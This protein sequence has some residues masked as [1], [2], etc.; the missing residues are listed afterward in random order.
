MADT[1]I[2][3]LTALTGAN[4]VSGDLLTIVDI[5]DTTMA[6]T[7]TNKKI[8]LTELQSA[9]VSA[10]TANGVLYLNG[11]KVATSGSA[12]VFDG[13]NLGIGTTS[14]SVKLQV[15]N[16]INGTPF[17]WGNATR[18]GYLYQDQN[19]VGITNASGTSFDEGVYLDTANSKVILYT[20]STDRVTLD[21]SGNLGLGVT[22]SAWTSYKAM[23]LSGSAYI[24]GFGNDE[25]GLGQGAYYSS[26]WK[27]AATGVPAT[28]YIAYRGSHIWQ[29]AP[30]G[31][32][33]NAITFTQA[34]T[35][36]ASG[37]LGIGTSSIFGKL[38]IADST[39]G[40]FEVTCVSA[41]VNLEVL[42][43]GR[44]NAADLNFYS[45]TVTFNTKDG[46]AYTEKARID[47]SGNLLVGATSQ[48]T[49]EKFLAD[50]TGASAKA[51]TARNNAGSGAATIFVWNS[52]TS[53]DNLFIGFGTEANGSQR[54]SI[55]YNRTGGL[56]A[57]NTTS[58][59]R[60]KD[61][62]GPVQNS[63]ALIDSV[64]VYMGKMKGATQERPMFI[65]HE[66]PA[67]AHTGEKDTVDADGNPVYQ[68]MDAS[69]LIPVMWAELQ[70]LRA[71][72]AA[73]ES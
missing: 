7:G 51:I 38:N 6:A 8:T 13:T 41:G 18:T 61:I 54:G 30:S 37:N 39:N 31:T 9:P 33:G 5:S 71:R 52:A 67:Y 65:A 59:Y 58:D 17:A 15:Y 23:Q 43:S 45:K 28:W 70:S 47:S 25:L 72:V 68:Q 48:L 49:G 62:I 46:G 64:P 55:S 44:T 19:G 36:D 11:S 3:G 2:S 29:T 40:R 73:L 63:G 16:N 34:M 50:T 26:G 10:G 57:Y 12:L 20:N 56:T 27:Y 66:T 21:S 14:P 1:K 60:A 35:L 24:Y 32:A 69:A 4:A 22:P 42:N 53:G